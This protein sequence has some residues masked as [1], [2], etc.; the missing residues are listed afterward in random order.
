MFE[1]GNTVTV[2]GNIKFK[3]EA[4]MKAVVH[5]GCIACGAC[6]GTCPEVFE[7]GDD[8]YAHAVGAVTPENEEDVKDARDGCPVSVIDVEE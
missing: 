2:F 3:E 8:G 4:N 5:E 7:F 6:V 1:M